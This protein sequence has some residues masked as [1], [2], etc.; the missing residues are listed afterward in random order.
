MTL[1][2]TQEPAQAQAGVVAELQIPA[3]RRSVGKYTISREW[4]PATQGAKITP[5]IARSITSDLTSQLP[6]SFDWNVV[7]DDETKQA[8]REQPPLGLSNN[9]YK[10][11]IPY[12]SWEDVVREAE[13]TTA[14]DKLG[15]KFIARAETF[16]VESDAYRPLMQVLKTY[17]P[18]SYSWICAMMKYLLGFNQN[19]VGFGPPDTYN[20]YRLFKEDVTGLLGDIGHN[21]RSLGNLTDVTEKEALYATFRGI[22]IE[23]INILITRRTLNGELRSLQDRRTD[24]S[25]LP[26]FGGPPRRR[27]LHILNTSIARFDCYIQNAVSLARSQDCQPIKD[28]VDSLAEF[29]VTTIERFPSLADLYEEAKSLPPPKEVKSLFPPNKEAKSVPP[30]TA[31]RRRELWSGTFT[32]FNSPH[33]IEAV[34]ICL[35]EHHDLS[36]PLQVPY[37]LIRNLGFGTYGSVEEVEDIVTNQVYARKV[38]KDVQSGSVSDAKKRYKSEIAIIRRLSAHKHIIRLF[39]SYTFGRD[40]CLILQPVANSGDLAEM[41]SKIRE[42]GAP[43][44]TEQQ[45]I[46]QRAFGCL[47]SGLEFMH[48]QRIRHKDIKPQNVLIHKKEIIYTDFGI[49]LDSSLLLGPTTSGRPIALSQRYA[50]PE[51]VDWDSRNALSDVFSLGCIYVELLAA[52]EPELVPAELLQSRFHMNIEKLIEVLENA[53]PTNQHLR[54]ICR[55]CTW[56]LPRK[57]SQRVSASQLFVKGF[58][59]FEGDR[60]AC[61]A[62][63]FC[64]SCAEEL[65]GASTTQSTIHLV[66]DLRLTDD[67]EGPP[68]IS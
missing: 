57:A 5:D 68:A 54:L 34:D 42:S 48:K 11:R 59:N 15:P 14:C 13:R 50:A 67:V 28:N 38:I 62:Q 32:Q 56:M 10:L 41:L 1:E 51:V 65:D 63:F 20:D 27:D 8:C 49:A 47:A 35:G 58:E 22:I 6:K 4:S 31:R 60:D 3:A 16:I 39:A 52:L 23:L 7:F 17:L 12:C 24:T 19:D 29:E 36:L 46:L 18:D 55:I 21:L 26:S 45:E 64:D 25:A 37:R 44:S 40:L 53:S 2:G 30:P 66:E 9:S 43:A 33:L 61:K